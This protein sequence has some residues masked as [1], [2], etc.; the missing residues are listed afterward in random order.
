[1]MFIQHVF[2]SGV[3]TLSSFGACFTACFKNIMALHCI[4]V[5][6]HTALVL[7]TKTY[8]FIVHLAFNL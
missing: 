6:V 1:M 2:D 4:K 5:L 7:P 8:E 3:V